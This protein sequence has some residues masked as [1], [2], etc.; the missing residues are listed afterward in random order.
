MIDVTVK[1]KQFEKVKELINGLEAET[2][3]GRYL[4]RYFSGDITFVFAQTPFTLSFHKGTM[5][6]AEVGKPITGVQVGLGGSEAHWEYFFSHRNFQLSTSPKHAE[7]CF[8]TLGSPLAYRQNNNT[9]A[10]LMRVIAKVMG[11]QDFEEE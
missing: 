2:F 4:A 10:Q 8:E 3:K 7:F 5:L 9:I 6:A 11:G 1:L